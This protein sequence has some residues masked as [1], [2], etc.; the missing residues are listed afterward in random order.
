MKLTFKQYL[1]EHDITSKES[2]KSKVL[3]KLPKMK[4]VQPPF[5]KGFEK[6]LKVKR[7]KQIK[8]PAGGKVVQVSNTMDKK[9]ITS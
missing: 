8:K 3:K 1:K 2:Q 7:A 6:L 5:T 4:K 9:T